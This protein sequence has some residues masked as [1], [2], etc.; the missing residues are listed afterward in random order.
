MQLQGVDTASRS[1]A[2]FSNGFRRCF[3]GIIRF[4]GGISG[5]H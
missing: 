1:F 4:A 3:N 5:P 2:G